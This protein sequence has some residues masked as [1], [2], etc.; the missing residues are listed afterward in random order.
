MRKENN[1]PWS[2]TG[3][4]LVMDTD[5]GKHNHP[6]IILAKRW[7]MDNDEA[8]GYEDPEPYHEAP[9][10]VYRGQ[11]WEKGVFPGNQNRTPIAK[12]VLYNP[13]HDPNNHPKDEGE[14]LSLLQFNPK[15]QIDLERKSGPRLYV[16]NRNCG[17]DLAYC[18][19]WY[20]LEGSRDGEIV[21]YNH[22]GLEY[23]RFNPR[24][25][26]YSFA[27]FIPANYSSD[28][29][30]AGKVADAGEQAQY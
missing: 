25:K 21:C 26:M 14:K 2:K 30:L 13:K 1:E 20:S 28:I 8:M 12:L 17:P 4:V 3:H 23:M 7:P 19:E 18:T 5:E 11:F 15:L 22:I 16:R 9:V 29:G 6:W 10:T 27:G 24:T